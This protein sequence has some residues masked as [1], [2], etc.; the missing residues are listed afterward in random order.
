MFRLS[1]RL[2]LLINSLL[3]IHKIGGHHVDALPFARKRNMVVIQQ[4]FS[5]NFGTK[6]S[7][8]KLQTMKLPDEATL[9]KVSF[10]IVVSLFLNKRTTISC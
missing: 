1:Q 10:M 6:R 9:H 8:F 5:I 3:V 4:S 2:I 7:L